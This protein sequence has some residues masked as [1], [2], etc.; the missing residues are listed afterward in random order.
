MEI[1]KGS[2]RTD[3]VTCQG[4]LWSCRSPF[5]QRFWRQRIRAGDS[6]NS[7]DRSCRLEAQHWVSRRI[8]RSASSGYL[9]L[10]GH[11]KVRRNF[12]KPSILYVKQNIYSAEN[13]VQPDIIV[14]SKQATETMEIVMWSADNLQGIA[15]AGNSALHK[16]PHCILSLSQTITFLHHFKPFLCLNSA[17][18]ITLI[19]TNI[20]VL[21]TFWITN[22]FSSLLPG[23]WSRGISYGFV[24][25]EN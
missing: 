12:F 21:C 17:F 14:Y 13:R 20:K 6:R 15:T 22:I 19:P 9:V 23:W 3:R 7:R 10:A 2:G 5:S 25:L 11:W 24:A 16:T 1:G 18:I 4:F 8:S